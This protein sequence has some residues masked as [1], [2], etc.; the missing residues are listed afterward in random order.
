MLIDRR[1]R[2]QEAQLA[3]GHDHVRLTLIEKP[4]RQPNEFAVH[5]DIGVVAT[6]CHDHVAVSTWR[7]RRRKQGRRPRATQHTLQTSFP[8][9]EVVAFTRLTRPQGKLQPRGIVTVDI[10][11]QQLQPQSR[12]RQRADYQFAGA[13]TERPGNFHLEVVAGDPPACCRSAKRRQRQVRLGPQRVGAR[14]HA[15]VKGQMLERVERVVVNE[16]PDRPLIGQHAPRPRQ[17]SGDRICWQVAMRAGG[18][19]NARRRPLHP[20]GR[21]R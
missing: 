11:A 5:S 19:V 8:P 18:H 14:A 7:A 2:R 17:R 3:S 12:A 13:I 15:L 16:H 20:R 1:H 6:L 21:C 10:G 4:R 9:R